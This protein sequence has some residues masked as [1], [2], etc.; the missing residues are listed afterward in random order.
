M[1]NW[2]NISGF[3]GLY[4]VSTNGMV[5]SLARVVIRSN[6]RPIHYKE[7]I[8]S[9]ATNKGYL[10]VYL[11]KDGEPHK[12]WVHRLVAEAFID[13]PD[14]LPQINHKD[15]DRTNNSVE[16]LEWCDAAYNSNYGTR[17]AKIKDNWAGGSKSVIQRTVDT[18]TINIFNSA[19]EA[20]RVTGFPQTSIS[21]WCRN[22]ETRNGFVW[23]YA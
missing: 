10:Y 7:K 11:W 2:I 20:G 17:N 1:I 16:N 14:N 12:K 6:G 4:Q 9:P 13:N 15:E 3:E 5:K 19:T 18:G 23:G 22:G 21:R 8:L